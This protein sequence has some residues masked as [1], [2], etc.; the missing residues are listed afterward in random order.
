MV[1]EVRQKYNKTARNLSSRDCSKAYII[2]TSNPR[3]ERIAIFVWVWWAISWR[4]HP[5]AMTKGGRLRQRL[6]DSSD[7]NPDHSPQTGWQ[8]ASAGAD[9]DNLIESLGVVLLFPGV[10]ALLRLAWWMIGESSPTR[11]NSLDHC[12]VRDGPR[13]VRLASS[14]SLVMFVSSQL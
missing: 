2:I 13:E 14:I 5:M 4:R 9:E 10:N 8:E 1:E 3:K 6:C 7:L 12:S 11:W